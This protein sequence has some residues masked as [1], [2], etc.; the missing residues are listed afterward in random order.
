MSASAPQVP[1][2]LGAL[3]MPYDRQ[4][5]KLSF[6]FDVDSGAEMAVTGVSLT[7][8]VGFDAV[9]AL[10]DPTDSN[11]ISFATTLATVMATSPLQW[12]AYS[13]LTTVKLAAVD[14][15]GH[16]LTDPRVVAAGAGLTGAFSGVHPQLSVEVGLRSVTK[17]GVANYGKMYLPHTA[18]PLFSGTVPW[19]GGSDQATILAALA[20][21]Y[22]GLN[23]AARM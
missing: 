15:A 4:H 2:G 20:P 21:W 7:G 17:I 12:A 6:I 9:A 14:T 22:T 19:C 23:G 11:L 5:L 8:D 10:A 1:S 13:S 3:P 16:Y 18:L